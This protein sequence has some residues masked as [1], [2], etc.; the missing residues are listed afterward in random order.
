MNS[1]ILIYTG[2]SYYKKLKYT[3]FYFF[4]RVFPEAVEVK[5]A[6]GDVSYIIQLRSYVNIQNVVRIRFLRNVYSVYVKF[7]F[8]GDCYPV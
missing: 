5:I 2:S 8:P 1:Q 6:S 3:D 7:G 4:F